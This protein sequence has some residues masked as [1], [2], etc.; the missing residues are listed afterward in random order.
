MKLL[1]DVGSLGKV[2]IVAQEGKCRLRQIGQSPLLDLE[3][4]RVV[5][6]Q[7]LQPCR[8]LFPSRASR[9][10]GKFRDVYTRTNQ[11]WSQANPN[12]PDRI[13]HNVNRMETIDFPV[14]ASLVGQ[15]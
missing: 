15:W 2:L 4:V 1:A 11:P 13:K 9:V 6:L 10:I 8:P 7:P 5:S 14:I 12:K 3:L